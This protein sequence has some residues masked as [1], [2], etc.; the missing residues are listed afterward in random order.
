MHVRIDLMKLPPWKVW[1]ARILK[2]NFADE[3]S[4]HHKPRYYGGD[5]TSSVLGR[6]G[7]GQKASG[8]PH[9]EQT[10]G[11]WPSNTWHCAT[12]DGKKHN[13]TQAT[14]LDCMDLTPFSFQGREPRAS[15]DD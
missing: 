5:T 14:G 11:N 10:T 8:N 9:R 3:S 15:G 7:T 1:Q 2:Q 4:I 13:P 6:A 12:E